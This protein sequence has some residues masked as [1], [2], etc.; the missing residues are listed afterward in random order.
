MSNYEDPGLILPKYSIITATYNAADTLDACIDSVRDQ[1]VDVEHIL[2]DGGSTDATLDIANTYK[3]NL[4]Q[5]VSEPDQGIY[6]AM[7]KGIQMATG[8][9]IGILN[10]DDFYPSNKILSRVEEVFTDKNIEAC[11]GDLIYGQM[12]RHPGVMAWPGCARI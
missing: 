4:S 1:D 3:D 7:N 2:V 11:Y 5:I 9:V 10:A 8:E 6:D 12:G